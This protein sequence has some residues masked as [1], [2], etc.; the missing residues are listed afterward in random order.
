M[1]NKKTEAL[2]QLIKAVDQ[3]NFDLEAWKIKAKLIL[4]KIFGSDDPKLTLIEAL[5]YD[6]SSWSLR[7]HSG[8]RQHDPIKD[9]ARELIETALIELSLNE[10]EHWIE[11]LLKKYLTGQQYDELISLQHNSEPDKAA[12]SEYFSK[13]A[14]EIKDQLLV[15]ILLSK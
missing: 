6:Y 13:I 4:Q 8:G 12:L 2:H 11:V 9:Q 15:Q 14:P 10:D 7:D 3:N 1:E 5:H